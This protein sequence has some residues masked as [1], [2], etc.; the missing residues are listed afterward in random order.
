MT[1]ETTRAQQ[2]G[3]NIVMR[4]KDWPT[5]PAEIRRS[6][7]EAILVRKGLVVDSGQRRWSKRTGRYETVWESFQSA[8]PADIKI[9]RLP[10]PST[11]ATVTP[12]T[13]RGRFQHGQFRRRFR[14]SVRSAFRAIFKADK[15]ASEGLS[16]V[17]AH[18]RKWRAY[19]AWQSIENRTMIVC[20]E[21]S[22]QAL[23]LDGCG[24]DPVAGNA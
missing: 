24:S 6:I 2:K 9:S 23:W 20:N 10:I 1:I 4:R 18:V 21:G 3:G 8:R 12:F 22:L 11:A 5:D 7:D 19:P 13:R 16:H 14:Q 15:V 17:S